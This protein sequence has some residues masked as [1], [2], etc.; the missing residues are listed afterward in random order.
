MGRRVSSL[1]LDLEGMTAMRALRNILLRGLATVLPVVVTFYLLWWL[2]TT[3]E[4]LL[5]AAL[6]TVLPPDMYRPG[7]GVAAAVVLVFVVGLMADAWLFGSVVRLAER[8][9]ERIPIVKTVFGGVR[10]LSAFLTGGG[11]ERL[12]RVVHVAL[13]P[14]IGAIGFITRDEVG[15]LAPPDHRDGRVAVYLPMS[16]QIGGYTLLVPRGCVTPLD[17][18]AEEAMRLVL[19]AGVTAPPR[20]GP[21]S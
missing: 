16:Y 8:A 1:T 15:G 5:G 21:P 10:D 17:L 20:R 2:A 14:D 4:S 18:P 3:G 9:L 6:R 7:M 11:Q 12:G 13:T 19:T